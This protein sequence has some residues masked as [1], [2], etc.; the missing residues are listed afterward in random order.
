MARE[1][2]TGGTMPSDDLLL[3]F[4]DDLRAVDHWRIG[5]VHYARTLEAWLARLDANRQAALD[6]FRP[7]LGEVGA[8]RQLQRSR[9]FL[10]ACSELFNYRDGRE[11]WVSHYTFRRPAS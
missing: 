10:L 4:Q 1:F 7:D 3:R 2:F 11:W 8:Q 9:L 5:G 6:I